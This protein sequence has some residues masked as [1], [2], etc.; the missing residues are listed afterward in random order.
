MQVDRQDPGRWPT[1]A[2]WPHIV[3]RTRRTVGPAFARDTFVL[4]ELERLTD[5]PPDA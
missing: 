1:P 4:T 5:S 2:S 3:R